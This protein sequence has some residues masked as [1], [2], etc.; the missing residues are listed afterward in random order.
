MNDF[1][2]CPF[3]GCNDIDIRKKKTVIIECKECGALFIKMT[4][5][6]AKEAWNER[7][8]PKKVNMK[9]YKLLMPMPGLSAGAVFLHDKKDAIKGSIGCGCLKL[10]WKNR[11]CQDGWCAETHILPGQLAEDLNWFKEIKHNDVYSL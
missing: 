9:A 8:K 1:L 10:A 6:E 11:N 5:E 2:P 4:I 7:N 3:C